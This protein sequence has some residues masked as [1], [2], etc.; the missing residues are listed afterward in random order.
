MVDA[1]IALTV[2]SHA[3]G[4]DGVDPGRQTAS[5]R[6]AGNAASATSGGEHI[7]STHQSWTRG[8]DNVI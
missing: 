7:G 8:R 4:R 6:R 1:T 2:T 5:A 3:Y